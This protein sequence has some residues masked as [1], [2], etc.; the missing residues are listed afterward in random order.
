MEHGMRAHQAAV[1]PIRYR[2]VC[3]LFFHL[4]RVFRIFRTI[5][6]E[7]L[8]PGESFKSENLRPRSFCFSFSLFPVCS[9]KWFES[10]FSWKIPFKWHGNDCELSPPHNPRLL[11]M[12]FP[13]SL[14]SKS[15]PGAAIIHSKAR[16]LRLISFHTRFNGYVWPLSH[17]KHRIWGCD[18][19]DEML[20]DLRQQSNRIVHFRSLRFRAFSLIFN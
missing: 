4:V 9:L 11:F 1:P 10:E 3:D 19:H 14:S 6:M 16:S 20:K 7:M 8:G 5:E 12:D 18:E 15:H 2:L 17:R 13:P